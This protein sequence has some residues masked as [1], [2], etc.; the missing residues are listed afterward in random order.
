M[1]GLG[2]VVWDG[3]R[4]VVLG[5]GVHAARVQRASGQKLALVRKRLGLS[6]GW[7]GG[8]GKFGAGIVSLV[9]VYV[10]EEAARVGVVVAG[11]PGAFGVVAD[12]GCCLFS[13]VRE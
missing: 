5:S 3:P 11:G 10:E 1:R 2:G 9:A 8:G 7:R 4:G 12:P 6:S 13:G